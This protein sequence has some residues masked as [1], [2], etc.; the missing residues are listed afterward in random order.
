MDEYRSSDRSRRSGAPAERERDEE[1]IPSPTDDGTTDWDGV[2]GEE[3]DVDVDVDVDDAGDGRGVPM[4]RGAARGSERS[5]RTKPRASAPGPGEPGPGAGLSARRYTVAAKVEHLRDYAL[6]TLS[7]RAFCK[8]RGLNTKSFCRWRRAY[9]A[10]GEAGLIARPNRRNTGGRTGRVVSPEERRAL[11]EAY[12]KLKLPQA[13]FAQTYGISVASLGNWLRAYRQGGPKGLEPKQRGR[14][15]GQG[16]KPLLPVPVRDSIVATKRRFPSFGLKK[17]RDYLLRF[18]GLKVSPGGV[19]ATLERSGLPPVLPV[20]KKRHRSADKVRRFERSRAQELWQSDITSFV[21]RR[22]SRR[23]YLT[24]FLDDFSRYV[25]A[26]RLA[27]RQKPTWCATRS[28]RAW[29]GLGSL[30]KC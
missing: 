19:R 2:P 27:V 12:L 14:K 8:E 18:F 3:A 20:V 10:L 23:V 28:W 25:V 13:A 22:E 17:I 11:V 1:R 6:S 29:R 30:W 5:S 26:F 21:L 15:K 4:G 9:K 24:V 16:G 7:L